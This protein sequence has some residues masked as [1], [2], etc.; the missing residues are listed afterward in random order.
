MGVSERLSRLPRLLGEGYCSAASSLLI[1][2]L[3]VVLGMLVCLF[4]CATQDARKYK[5]VDDED[6]VTEE[7]I[8]L[9]PALLSFVKSSHNMSPC[10]T[11]VRDLHT[12]GDAD[13]P[14]DTLLKPL[15]RSSV[16]Y[17]RHARDAPPSAD[18]SPL[19]DA[20]IGRTAIDHSCLMEMVMHGQERRPSAEGDEDCDFAYDEQA[21]DSLD[22]IDLLES[23][24][25]DEQ[26]AYD[27]PSLPTP[28][29]V[30][31]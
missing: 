19:A 22:L 12:L 9:P 14:R 18:T 7:V 25:D 8:P 4:R 21:E 29:R 10:S 24:R 23:L 5:R 20:A 26:P 15:L 13:H 16:P 11:M 3:D 30:C 31:M 27:A 2:V 28:T 1:F 17:Q 6:Q